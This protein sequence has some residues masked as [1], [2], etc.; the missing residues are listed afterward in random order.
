[1]AIGA[2]PT[3]L[4]GL[5]SGDLLL[6]AA[7]VTTLLQ[8][9]LL[10]LIVSQVLPDRV[11]TFLGILREYGACYLIAIIVV[12]A[13]TIA[14]NMLFSAV[15]P[16]RLPYWLILG[17]SKGMVVAVTIYVWPLVLLRRTSVSAIMAGVSVFAGNFAS[18]LWIVGIV[19]FG[20]AVLLAAQLAYHADRSGFSFAVLLIAGVVC[21]YSTASSFAAALHGL[22]GVRVSEETAEA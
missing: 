11:S 12:G 21:T 9:F 17:I 20:Q 15:A 18:S 1:V 7:F 13:V 4:A 14:V 10:G 3:F 8:V 22:L 19:L 6:P 5:V 2:G 16:S